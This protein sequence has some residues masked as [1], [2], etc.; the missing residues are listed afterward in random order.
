MKIIDIQEEVKIDQGDQVIIL[1]KGD[2]IR[3]LENSEVGHFIFDEIERGMR[4]QYAFI[5]VND[6]I[7][8]YLTNGEYDRVPSFEDILYSGRRI[9]PQDLDGN[10]TIE[11]AGAV[12]AW[13]RGELELNGQTI[14]SD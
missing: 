8:S 10:F 1:E 7:L 14:V 13:S 5:K 4:V 11:L 12:K 2:R 6:S 9:T 3:V